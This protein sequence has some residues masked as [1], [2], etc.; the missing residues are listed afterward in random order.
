MATHVRRR[1][2]TPPPGFPHAAPLSHKYDKSADE[3]QEVA[4]KGY[5][6]G[7]RSHS[8]GGLNITHGEWK[9]L[10]VRIP[11]DVAFLAGLSLGAV[12]SCKWVGL[13][14]SRRLF[15]RGDAF[16]SSAFRQTLGHG[17]QETYADVAFGSEIIIR[18]LN[19]QGGYLHPHAHNY[20][21]RM[22][23]ISGECSM[24]RS[25]AMNNATLSYIEHGT[26]IKLRDVVTDKAV[27]SHDVRPP[28]SDV[29]LQ[30]EVSAYGWTI[31]IE[32]ATGVT[33]SR[34]SA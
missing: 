12:V 10:A 22:R 21:G 7:K 4:S 3:R 6:P 32:R 34:A 31:E 27:H 5:G 16:M 24:Q 14:T 2:A 30:D 28:V 13:F 23:K 26:R 11:V 19:T 18:R 9:L 17:M 8:S 1:P 33:G 20:P 15:R 29:D 25:M